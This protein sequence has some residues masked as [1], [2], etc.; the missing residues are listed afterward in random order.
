MLS[1]LVFRA[2]RNALPGDP[3]AQEHIIG[4]SLFAMAVADAT[5]IAAS[6]IGLP[7]SLRYDFASWNGTTHGNITFVIFLLFSRCVFNVPMVA[8][9]I[10]GTDATFG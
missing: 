9:V 7:G 1:S 10:V 3:V 2:V 8:P 4:A 5:H 6:W